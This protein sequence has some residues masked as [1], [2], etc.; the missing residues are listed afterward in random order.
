MKCDAQ[1]PFQDGTHS[2][3]VRRVIGYTFSNIMCTQTFWSLPVTGEKWHPSAFN[4]HFLIMKRS[5][6]FFLSLFSYVK[7]H[8]ISIRCLFIFFDY[9][10]AE[11]VVFSILICGPSLFI[12]E[13]PFICTVS[14]TSF[15]SFVTC[16]LTRWLCW[17]DWF[18]QAWISL[19]CLAETHAQHWFRYEMNCLIVLLHNCGF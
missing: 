15:S 16:L 5:E 3:T 1:T 18:L 8:L 14:C 9:F 19:N 10:S 4:M 17:K 13:L 2:A 7:N 6:H 12:R 11:L